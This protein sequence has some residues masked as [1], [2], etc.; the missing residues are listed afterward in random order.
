MSK[1]YLELF[2]LLI[3]KIEWSIINGVNLHSWKITSVQ[4]SNADFVTY[5]F[6]VFKYLN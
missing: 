2:N 6:T 5:A 1:V 4:Y 3:L